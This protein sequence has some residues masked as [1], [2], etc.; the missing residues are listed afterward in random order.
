MKDMTRILRLPLLLIVIFFV[1]KLVMSYTGVPYETGVRIFS[2]VTL[3]IYLSVLWGGIVRHYEGYGLGGAIGVGFL[4]ALAS[5]VLIVAGTAISYVGGDTHF[6]NPTAL[7][8]ESAV[9]FGEAM[10]IRAVGLVANSVFGGVGGLLGYG[11][12][13]LAGGRG[14]RP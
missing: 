12:D 8:V 4:I 10:G 6:N 14:S 11:L 2:M 13:A 1:G 7:N 5:Q 9:G 3:Q